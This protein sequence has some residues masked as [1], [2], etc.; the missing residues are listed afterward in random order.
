MSHHG[1]QAGHMWA[2]STR[3][4]N[5]P[6]LIRSGVFPLGTEPDDTIREDVRA[7]GRQDRWSCLLTPAAV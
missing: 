6:I 5:N 2:G 3:V 1:R 4:G 7:Q